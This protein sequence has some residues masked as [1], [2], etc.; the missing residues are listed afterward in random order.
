MWGVWPLEDDVDDAS[1]QVPRD[2]KMRDGCTKQQNG[3]SQDSVD[4]PHLLEVFKRRDPQRLH[5]PPK[6]PHPTRL[7]VL[8]ITLF[9]ENQTH[10][11]NSPSLKPSLH[12]KQSDLSGAGLWPVGRPAN[13]FQRD[14]AIHVCATRP[15]RASKPRC[16]GIEAPDSQFSY[17]WCSRTQRN[18]DHILF[19]RALEWC[20][21]ER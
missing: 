3:H 6:T 21:E 18:K 8:K 12:S 5:N 13:S 19:G 16:I 17:V 10:S 9:A 4:V 2:I 14:L 11:R 1:S 20:L 15:A 7:K